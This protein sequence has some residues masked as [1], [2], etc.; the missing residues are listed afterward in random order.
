MPQV[1]PVAHHEKIPEKLS[2]Y[3]EYHAIK[4]SMKVVVYECKHVEQFK[5]EWAN[6]ISTFDLS[7][8]E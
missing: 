8:N 5:S 6:F 3:T 1:V 4:K 7:G 2:G